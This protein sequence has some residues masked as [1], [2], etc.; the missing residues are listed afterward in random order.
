MT[1]QSG[2]IVALLGADAGRD[3]DAVRTLLRRAA[4]WG[5]LSCL[6]GGSTAQ[7]V[8][9]TPG[10]EAQVEFRTTDLT[11]PT[12]AGAAPLFEQ[13]LNPNIQGANALVGPGR[14][15]R[16]IDNTLNTYFNPGAGPL[17]VA[18]GIETDP[19]F[20]LQAATTLEAVGTFIGGGGF[21]FLSPT[22]ARDPLDQ[23]IGGDLFTSVNV[24][25]AFGAFVNPSPVFVPTITGMVVGISGFL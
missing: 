16:S 11:G 1:D 21:V 10:H 7:A 17:P 18:T 8:V 3:R 13:R 24:T 15:F 5:V 4:C 9:I 22:G 23:A 2:S 6:I 19:V 20:G 14:G 12:A 25:R